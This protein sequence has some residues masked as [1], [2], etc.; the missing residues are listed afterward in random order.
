MSFLK[1]FIYNRFFLIYLIYYIFL[2]E[3]KVKKLSFSIGRNKVRLENDS[4]Y[5]RGEGFISNAYFSK[6][7]KI[8]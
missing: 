6:S 1:F 4:S 3:I 5:G 2:I 8:K 7:D